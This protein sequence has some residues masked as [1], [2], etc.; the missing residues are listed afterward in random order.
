MLEPQTKPMDDSRLKNI[1]RI[2][3]C[4]C[5]SVASVVSIPTILS[6][7]K[8]KKELDNEGDMSMESP[9]SEMQAEPLPASS[10]HLHDSSIMKVLI[11][12]LVYNC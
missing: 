11:T 9:D 7:K 4:L 12:Y 5:R 3:P 10:T 6:P 2:Y 8:I 1:M